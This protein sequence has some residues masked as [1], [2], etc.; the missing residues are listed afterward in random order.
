MNGYNDSY[1]NLDLSS[2]GLDIRLSVTDS[3]NQIHAH[4]FL[5]DLED[6]AFKLSQYE[7]VSLN[8]STAI[9]ANFYTDTH[10]SDYLPHELD[11]FPGE[12]VVQIDLFDE[13]DNFTL[14]DGATMAWPFP[15]ATHDVVTVT[16][17]E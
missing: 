16:V 2:Y 9:G 3:F 12:D 6:L 8:M 11:T 14:N 7:G 1:L 5:K 13:Y 15:D 17:E 4:E 10:D